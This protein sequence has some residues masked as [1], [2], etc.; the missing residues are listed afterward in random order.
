MNFKLLDMC[1][2]TSAIEHL[3]FMF[4]LLQNSV[5]RIKQHKIFH[6]LVCETCLNHRGVTFKFCQ[7]KCKVPYTARLESL[8]GGGSTPY[9][10]VFGGNYI[11]HQLGSCL[12]LVKCKTGNSWQKKKT[13]QFEQCYAGRAVASLYHTTTSCLADEYIRTLRSRWRRLFYV[14]FSAQQ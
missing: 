11:L 10:S 9:Q 8:C 3:G 12:I 2:E 1:V 5:A 4:T 7:K 13:E 14:S 6:F